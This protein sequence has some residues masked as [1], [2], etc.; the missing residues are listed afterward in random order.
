[1]RIAI[2]TSPSVKKGAFVTQAI[3]QA[4][5]IIAADCGANAALAMGILPEIVVGDFD[6]LEEATLRKLQEKKIPM[7]RL[8]EE[9]DEVDTQLAISYAIKQGATEITLVGGIEGNRVEHTLAN[10]SLTYNPKL[11]IYIVNGP[12]K[13]WVALGPQEVEM[14]GE[15]N[16]LLSLIPLSQ[17]V[18]NIITKGLYYPLLDEPLYFGVSRGISNVFAEETASV[19]FKE[20]LLAF[21]HTKKEELGFS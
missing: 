2:F 8:P 15:K 12:S 4:D 7:V 5:K 18:A 13:I 6:S 3:E 14:R 1:M 17:I 16:D 21:V 20:G 19:A 10:V 11:P 9:K